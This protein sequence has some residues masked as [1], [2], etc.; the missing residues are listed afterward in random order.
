MISLIFNL[1]YTCK[2]LKFRSSPKLQ[3][4]KMVLLRRDIW[5]YCSLCSAPYFQVL[6]DMDED[7]L[8]VFFSRLSGPSSHHCRD[9]SVSSGLLQP[10]I[11]LSS[12]CP[13]ISCTRGS[14]TGQSTPSAASP[15]LSR[16]GDHLSWPA[17]STLPHAAKSTVNFLS[18]EGI[19]L[20]H[21]QVG[22]QLDPQV[23]F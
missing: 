14:R 17:N 23:L 21:V 7:S 2:A 3:N 11:E 19:F 12:V 9:A 6:M 22:A 8:G 4:H 5:I 16:G 15:V 1:C 18:H 10:Y 20:T 13:G